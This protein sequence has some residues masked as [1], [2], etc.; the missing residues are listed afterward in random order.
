MYQFLNPSHHC[1]QTEVITSGMVYGPESRRVRGPKADDLSSEVREGVSADD[2]Q[3]RAPV[4]AVEALGK[5]P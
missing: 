3:I 1:Y 2:E 4:S 5:G